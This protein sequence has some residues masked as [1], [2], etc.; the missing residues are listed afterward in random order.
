[1]IIVATGHRPNKILV[2]GEPAYDGTAFE[3]LRSFARSVLSGQTQVRP[4][5][6][7]GM[8]LGWDQAIAMAAIDLDYP[9]H[10][11]VPFVGQEARWPKE[12][13]HRYRRILENAAR[14]HIVSHGT[15]A[16][17][18]LHKRNQEMVMVADRIVAL[19]DGS[20]GG[21]KN[22]IDYAKKMQ[23]GDIIHNYW[24]GWAWIVANGSAH[25]RIS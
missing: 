8:A 3:L 12:S 9:L 6:V 22:C 7:G 20:D 19:W 16:A 23:K 4:T 11:Y 5:I 24:E 25:V 13:Q 14:V 21:T 1:M 10:A 15:Y 18:K 2:N 17:W